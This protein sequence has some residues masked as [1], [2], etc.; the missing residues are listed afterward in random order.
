MAHRRQITNYGLNQNKKLSNNDNF[1]QIE[2]PISSVYNIYF[3]K[4]QLSKSSNKIPMSKHNSPS[5]V[6]RKIPLDKSQFYSPNK[7]D[8]RIN[9]KVLFPKNRKSKPLKN[10][11]SIEYPS[12]FIASS[13]KISLSTVQNKT[14]YKGIYVRKNRIASP[15]RCCSEKSLKNVFKNKLGNSH[16]AL[17]PIKVE[18]CYKNNKVS[19]INTINNSK[20]KKNQ[21]IININLY[22]EKNNYIANNI[23][24]TIYINK[25]KN[26]KNKAIY[27]KKINNSI[28][29]SLTNIHNE[30]VNLTERNT[31][32]RRSNYCLHY[33]RNNNIKNKGYIIS[34]NNSKRKL[35]NLHKVQRKSSKIIKDN[36]YKESLLIKI[37]SII[38]GYLLNKKL[39]KYLRQYMHINDGIKRIEFIFKKKYFNFIKHIRRSKRKNY[40]FKNIY[41]SNKNKRNNI[42]S[43]SNKEKNVELQFKIN[44][45]IHEKIELQNNYDN[46]KE[47]VRKYKELEK[48]NK[49]IKN[50]NEKLKLKNKELL[51]KLN[52]NKKNI[53]N[54]NLNKYKRF[55][56]QNQINLNII[57]PKR[58]DL[59]YRKYNLNKEI[60]KNNKNDFFTLGTGNDDVEQ[61]EKDELL[62]ISK[63][64]CLLK[65]KENNIRFIL[66]KS[67]VK[68]Y[69]NA[70]HNQ[71]IMSIPV[72]ISNIKS[73]ISS[74]N[75]RYNHNTETSNNL[76]NCMSIKTLSDNS[77]IFTERK[78]Q[79]MQIENKLVTSNFLIEDD[80]KNK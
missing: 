18:K 42:P 57:S 79:N 61:D 80:N 53:F 74:I 23:V 31:I 50:E 45:L 73:N 8:K 37:Q 4:E 76:F 59:I 1:T 70:L 38:R 71:N 65:N 39:D 44:E 16:L 21:N 10:K 5:S 68:F 27:Q 29:S 36:H 55:S 20:S 51:T 60:K 49:E 34:H 13:K 69:Y 41:H 62:K 9:Y 72:D 78:S 54:Y 35:N 19:Y 15:K 64:K 77:S 56:I 6:K 40:S 52:A 30:S 17:T 33:N 58:V 63:L 2:K 3:N 47:F 22:N 11:C 26:K 43:N 24:N 75:K 32:P 7:I 48:E 12:S 46:L 67:F 28:N 66:F 25:N 14:I